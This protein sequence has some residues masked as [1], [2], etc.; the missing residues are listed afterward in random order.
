MYFYVRFHLVFIILLHLFKLVNSVSPLYLDNLIC[1]HRPFRS[2]HSV[3]ANLLFVPC[4]FSKFGDRIDFPKFSVCGALLRNNLPN[5]L[6]M[7]QS[8]SHFKMLLKIHLNILAFV[9]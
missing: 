4:T 8:L 1:K 3:D 2:L 9:N 7:A 6:K 5:Q